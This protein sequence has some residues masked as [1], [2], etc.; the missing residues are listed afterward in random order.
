MSN[1]QNRPKVGLGVYVIDNAKLLLLKRQGAHGEGSWCPPGGHLESGESFAD[2]AIREAK[3]E[4]GIEID[5]IKVIGLT[6]DIFSEDKHYITI[7]TVGKLKSGKAKIM[8]P[9]KA[10]DIGWFELDNLPSL[11][12]LPTQNLFLTDFDCFCDSGKKYKKCCGR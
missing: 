8:E 10:T 12:F 5:D 9:D 11:M 3:E 7:A 2:C 1:K 6:N 4:A